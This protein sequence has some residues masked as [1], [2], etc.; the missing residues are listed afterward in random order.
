MARRIGSR[1]D[2]AIG[3]PIAFDDLKRLGGRKALLSALRRR[4]Y[5]LAATLIAEP[6]NRQHPEQEYQFPRQFEF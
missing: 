2:V 5:D 6:K 3:D 4:I 1:L